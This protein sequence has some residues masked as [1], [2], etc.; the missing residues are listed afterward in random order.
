MINLEVILG[1]DENHYENVFVFYSWI[2]LLH[3]L[4]IFVPY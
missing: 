2:Y 4:L 3:L 1:N